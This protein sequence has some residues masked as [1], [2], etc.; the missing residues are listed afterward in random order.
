[1]IKL[2]LVYPYYNNPRCLERQLQLWS[3]LP[4]EAA[5][6]VEY[7]LVDDGSPGPA[8]LSPR[9]PLN[10]TLVRIKE[11][12]PWNQHGARNLGMK[13]A[14]G[15]WAIVSDIDHLLP[16]DGLSFL[17]NMPKETG[18]VYYF[19]RRRED[20]TVKHPHPNSFLI[21]RRAFWS[22]GGYDEDF[23]GHYGKGDIFLRLLFSRACAVVPLDWPALIELDDAATPG[24]IRRTRHN[25]WLAKKKRWQLA[26]GRYRNGR[27]LRFEWEIVHRWRTGPC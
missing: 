5:R 24:L 14:E 21:E 8:E 19:G 16:A 12:K 1:M 25:R 26:R 15:D 4:P 11:D 2:S 7:V 6:Q 18:S 9:S 20:G 3:Q 13:L 10:I 17:L 27:T 23:C 22:L